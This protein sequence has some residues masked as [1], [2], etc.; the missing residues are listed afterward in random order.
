METKTEVFIAELYPLQK[1]KYYKHT[2]K[3]ETVGKY[4]NARYY[5][6]ESDLKYVGQYSHC[7]DVGYRD[8]QNRYDYF[9]HCENE[10][11]IDHEC[12]SRNYYVE[13]LDV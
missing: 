9:I 8:S 6:I 4:P 2:T 3:V 5:A 13:C 7:K 12:S 1:D 10:V 11:M